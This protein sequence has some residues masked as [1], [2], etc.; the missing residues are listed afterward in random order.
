MTKLDCWHA[1]LLDGGGNFVTG[2]LDI[3]QHDRMKTSMLELANRINTN[4]TL[5]VNFNGGNAKRY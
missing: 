4:I 1:I 5:L 3:L 2:K